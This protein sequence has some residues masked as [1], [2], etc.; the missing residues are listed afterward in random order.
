MDKF[1]DD[2]LATR[3]LIQQ[4][5]WEDKVLF[6]SH[7]EVAVMARHLIPEVREMNAWV[8]ELIP[9]WPRLE[10]SAPEQALVGAVDVWCPTIDH[11]EPAMLKQRMDA[12]DRLW[13]YTVW[14]RPG[15]M[16]EF[17]STDPR[18]MFWECWKYGAEGFLYW[19]T[20]H[21]YYNVQGDARWPGRPWITYNSQPGHNGC[22]YMIYPGPDGTPLASIRLDL[23]RDG[24]EDYEYFHMLKTR[25]ADKGAAV[26]EEV[27]AHAEAELAVDPKVVVDNKRFTENPEDILAARQRIAALIME[28][29]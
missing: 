8:K 29:K 1:Q 16:I 18:L 24:I 14:D 15:V 7:D 12:G 4:K 19:G 6:Y 11:F 9:A 28:L 3:D 17:P 26:P 25:L 13:L 23:A 20:T 21:W 10:T 27:R 2:L 5:G 22:G